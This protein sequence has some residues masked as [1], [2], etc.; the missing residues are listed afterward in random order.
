VRRGRWLS[1]FTF[2]ASSRTRLFKNELVR[3]NLVALSEGEPRLGR[4]FGERAKQQL[5]D[6]QRYLSRKQRDSNRRRY[7]V[8]VVATLHRKVANQR[9]NAA[10]QRV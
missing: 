6:A 8:D 9:R 5:A 2:S 7:Q 3:G 1:N 4:R 10:G